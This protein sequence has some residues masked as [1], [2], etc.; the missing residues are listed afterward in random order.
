MIYKKKQ[1]SF[2]SQARTILEN[3]FKTIIYLVLAFI[4]FIILFQFYN[5]QKEK[6][7]LKLSILFDQAKSSVDVNDF[8]EAMN[9]VAKKNG[10]FGMLAS[11]EL[12]E[13]N[14]NNK[15]YDYAYNQ[16]LK[17]IKRNESKKIYNSIIIT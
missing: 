13:K 2:I 3:K 14:L 15:D 8:E 4:I 5:Y 17:L 16:Y 10:I 7:I 12:I 6:Q 1:T 11:L 9:I